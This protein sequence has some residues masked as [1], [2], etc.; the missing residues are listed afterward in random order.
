MTMDYN[1]R[2]ESFEASNMKINL[3]YKIRTEIVNPKSV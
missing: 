3:I 1:T 2:N